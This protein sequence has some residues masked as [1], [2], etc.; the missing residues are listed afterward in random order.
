MSRD[1]VVCIS[2]DR[3]TLNCIFLSFSLSLSHFL[4]LLLSIYL[5]STNIRSNPDSSRQIHSPGQFITGR[6]AVWLGLEKIYG[7]QEAKQ[8][9]DELWR[10]RDISF[11]SALYLLLNKADSL[12]KMCLFAYM[13]IE[14]L[15]TT[16]IP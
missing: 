4:P 13:S 9:A 2:K 10:G 8:E 6:P 14:K 3:Q 11:F 15:N 1:L 12:G 5:Q 16:T 7:R